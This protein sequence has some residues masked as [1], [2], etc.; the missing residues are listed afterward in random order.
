MIEWTKIDTESG[1]ELYVDEEQERYL[2]QQHEDSNY[3]VVWVKYPDAFM[4]F[5]ETAKK[6]KD[7][8]DV[9]K[10]SCEEQS[11]FCKEFE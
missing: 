9:H 1:F 10:V 3:G 2:I 8:C 7:F 6:A 5:C 11:R 4:I